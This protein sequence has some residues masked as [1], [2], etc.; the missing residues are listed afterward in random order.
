MKNNSQIRNKSE[1]LTNIG[2]RFLLLCILLT[3]HLSNILADEALAYASKDELL[4]AL[5]G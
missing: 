5:G 2:F 3:S 4:H 1:D